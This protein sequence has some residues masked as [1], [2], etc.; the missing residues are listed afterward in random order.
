MPTAWHSTDTVDVVEPT[1]G[2]IL[3]SVRLAWFDTWVTDLQL[4]GRFVIVLD[5]GRGNYSQFGQQLG[6][7]DTQR[8]S[9]LKNYFFPRGA[10]KSA[11]FCVQ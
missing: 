3:R 7:F 9:N 8:G 10:S 2:A 4:T 6:F 5:D 1:S 11:F